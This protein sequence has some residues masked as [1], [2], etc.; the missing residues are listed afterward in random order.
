MRPGY[1][2]LTA[3]QAERAAEKIRAIY[4]SL[5]RPDLG[6]EH[7]VRHSLEDID[8]AL[9]V[10]AEKG[11]WFDTEAWLEDESG[12]HFAHDFGGILRHFDPITGELVDCFLPRYARAAE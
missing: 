1:Y 4:E 7:R 5:K 8:R 11:Y 3:G 12:F 9:Y 10:L 6:A 2:Y